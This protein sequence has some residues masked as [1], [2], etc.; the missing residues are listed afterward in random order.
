MGRY[1]DS[2]VYQAYTFLNKRYWNYRFVAAGD[3]LVH[4]CPSWQ[5]ASGDEASIRD[6]LPKDKQFLITRNVPCYKRCRQMDD[7]AQEQEKVLGLDD[8]LEDGDGGWVDT[9][10]YSEKSPSMD[11]REDLMANAVSE[12][13]LGDEQAKP[14]TN[15]PVD[16]S[17][18]GLYIFHT[19]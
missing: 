19:E 7:Y 4:H 2:S 17:D 14:S 11:P 10:H 12:M 1:E 13:T 9:H 5:W 15:D 6:Y 8:D 18:D 16:D 3:H